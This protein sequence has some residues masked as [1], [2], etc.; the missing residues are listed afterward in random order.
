MA[1]RAD[2]HVVP[3]QLERTNWFLEGI[4]VAF[5]VLAAWNLWQ[6]GQAAA[7]VPL[8]VLVALWAATSDAAVDVQGVG[9]VAGYLRSALGCRRPHEWLWVY[10]RYLLLRH[11]PAPVTLPLRGGSLTIHPKPALQP[12]PDERRLTFLVRPDVNLAL[13]DPEPRRARMEALARVLMG[14]GAD[15]RLLVQAR[16]VRS[17]DRPDWRKPIQVERRFVVEVD[18]TNTSQ[19]DVAD[20]LAGLGWHVEHVPA[21]RLAER[22][23]EGA[24]QL[25]RDGVR[26]GPYWSASLVLRRWA[27]SVRIGWVGQALSLDLPVDVVVEIHPED[28]DA[29]ARWLQG[30][31]NELA[32][33]ERMAATS[34]AGRRLAHTDADTQREQLLA[35]TNKPARVA[36]MLTVRARDR[37]ELRERVASVRHR[38]GIALADVQPCHGE[39]DLGRLATEPGGSVRVLR[40]FRRLD[41]L[42]AAACWPFLPVTLDHSRGALVGSPPRERWACAWTR[43]TSRWRVSAAS[44]SARP[45]RA[46]ATGSSAWCSGC[47][48]ASATTWC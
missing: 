29:V 48:S 38:F 20:S 31:V 15:C 18:G 47:W 7:A 45:A 30:R 9:W 36:V 3:T 1:P 28:P 13:L 23:W 46:R 14:L 37:Q 12:T 39:H 22:D 27:R 33:E 35:T 17:Q 16:P 32:D 4:V 42:S 43:S 41:F 40:A 19:Q 44:S 10:A 21:A 2:I 5:M 24:V 34:N 26:H 6:G 11:W 8:V 25:E